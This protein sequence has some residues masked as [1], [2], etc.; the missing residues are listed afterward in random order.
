VVE[1]NEIRLYYG[2]ADKCVALAFARLDDV[3]KWLIGPE[4][5]R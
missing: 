3:L 5:K 1:E 2:G 4:V